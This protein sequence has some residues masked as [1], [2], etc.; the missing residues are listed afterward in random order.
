MGSAA[1]VVSA[2]STMTARLMFQA[3]SEVATGVFALEL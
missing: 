3:L 1:R 2:A